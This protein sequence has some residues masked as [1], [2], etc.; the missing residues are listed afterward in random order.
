[1][2]STGI[3]AKPGWFGSFFKKKPPS[4]EYI[5]REQDYNTRKE[6][7]RRNWE[8]ALK[9]PAH[10]YLCSR[11]EKASL[12]TDVTQVVGKIC[13][14]W[15]KVDGHVY[16]TPYVAEVMGISM[17]GQSLLLSV[18]SG[19]EGVPISLRHDGEAWSYHKDF[20]NLVVANFQ[21]V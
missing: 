17:C 12:S 10:E 2:T 5:K 21:F 19:P 7:F 1:M 14:F 15:I 3:A 8:A 11:L 20:K 18:S 4:A 13:S 6:E 9:L 16:G